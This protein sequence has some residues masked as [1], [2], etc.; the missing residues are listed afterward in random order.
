MGRKKIS[1]GWFSVAPSGAWMGLT[2]KP[3]VS[4]WATICRASGAMVGTSRCDVPARQLSEGGTTVV[5]AE[6]F[7]TFGEA[8]PDAALGDAD[9]AARHPYHA[10]CAHGGCLQRLAVCKDPKAVWGGR[11]GQYAEES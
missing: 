9:G 7:R 1:V 3:T 8:S 11:T 5:W 10:G 4:P 2:T 6:S